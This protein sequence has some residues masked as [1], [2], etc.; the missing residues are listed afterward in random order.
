MCVY[1]IHSTYPGRGPSSAPPSHAL[2]ATILYAIHPYTLYCIFYLSLSLYIYIYICIYGG[3]DR[4]GLRDKEHPA[5]L[6]TFL[7][8]QSKPT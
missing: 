4:G 7:G 6:Q 5:V 2:D 1:I 8:G 3:G